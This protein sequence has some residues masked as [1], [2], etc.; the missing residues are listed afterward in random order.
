MRGKVDEVGATSNE[1]LLA[2]VQRRGTARKVLSLFMHQVPA[3]VRNGSAKAASS[4]VL[5]LLSAAV[6]RRQSEWRQ[7]LTEEPV[8]KRQRVNSNKNDVVFAA[9]MAQSLVKVYAATNG[10]TAKEEELDD[11]VAA[12][13]LACVALYVVCAL[14][15]SVRLGDLV[16]DN[17]LYQVAKKY[18]EMPKMRESAC[19]VAACVHIRLWQAHSKLCNGSS[20]KSH[21]MQLL[22]HRGGDNATLASAVVTKIE[23]VA[24]LP[25]PRSFHTAQFA[26]LLLGHTNT[27]VTLLSAVK[28][29]EAVVHVAETTL[30]PW[31]DHLQKVPGQDAK[32]A[33]SF[34]DRTF[35]ILWKFAA[36]VGNA[37]QTTLED[38][39]VA[40][41]FRS[42]ALPF[43]LKCSNYSTSYFI[44]QVHRIGVQHERSTR[45]SDKG[46]KELHEFYDRSANALTASLPISRQVYRSDS[47]QWEYLQWLQHFAL[48]CEMSGM[49][50]K[51]AKI[52][53]NAVQYAQLFGKTAEPIQ[54][55]LLFSI[56]GDLFSASS[57]EKQGKASST[58]N[59][60]GSLSIE[61]N[62][63]SG[64][65]RIIDDLVFKTSS[66]DWIEQCEK[67]ARVYLKKLESLA[68][69]NCSVLGSQDRFVVFMTR[70]VKR[71]AT[72]VFNYT[73]GAQHAAKFQLYH[74]V[75]TSK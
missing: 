37:G 27:C 12:M 52:L 1:Q 60:F 20:E 24:E 13:D 50:L 72:K 47:L 74:Q 40:L 6:E 31:I 5:S 28:N 46:L 11:L 57:S 58:R 35:R 23:L 18:A 17:L 73:I 41:R 14:D 30:S 2:L 44:Q 56:A 51:S 29:H 8:I 32:L 16:A 36:T 53:E 75:I 64:P 42:A 15:H 39:S 45:R 70:I 63:E 61:K 19:C 69:F 38:S 66:G 43:L 49:H 71:S 34:S 9:K 33:S 65:G 4:T 26:R 67:A 55:C 3:M 48:M 7:V 25:N 22:D 59:R 54:S 62:M 68:P 10:A 21:L